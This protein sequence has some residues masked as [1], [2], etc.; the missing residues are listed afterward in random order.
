MAKSL[1]LVPSRISTM[2]PLACS[3]V[4]EPIALRN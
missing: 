4:R 1:R 3:A 2:K